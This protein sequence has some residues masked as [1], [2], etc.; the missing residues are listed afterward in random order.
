MKYF[1]FIVLAIL[2]AMPLGVMASSDTNK[3]YTTD[4]Y[5]EGENPLE[6]PYKSDT[7]KEV[8][9]DELYDEKVDSLNRTFIEVNKYKY[10]GL[11]G[12][13]RI[14][15]RQTSNKDFNIKNVK[16]YYEGEKLSYTYLC[17]NCFGYSIKEAKTEFNYDISNEMKNNSVVEL[18]LDKEY[19]PLDLKVEISYESNNSNNLS[20]IDIVYYNYTSDHKYVLKPSI[21]PN[22]YIVFNINNLSSFSMLEL[23]RE[24]I[25]NYKYSDDIILSNEKLNEDF[26]KLLEVST[27]YKY[28]DRVYLYYKIKSEEGDNTKVDSGVI[29]KDKNGTYNTSNNKVVDKKPKVVSLSKVVNP[30]L[31][32]NM[33]SNSN[34]TIPDL[35]EESINVSN[36][37]M[38]SE[39]KSNKFQHL[40]LAIIFII[41]FL[42]GY[43]L[44]SLKKE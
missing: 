38:L 40:F 20:G 37:K 31:D 1:K 11:L 34:K 22:E 4:Y 15:I 43:M 33:N 13:D 14:N 41:L 35:K 12:V 26:Y 29:L 7:F 19:N 6:Y 2:V 42:M 36:K 30:N 24:N 8:V 27:K 17:S 32:K 44:Y 23:K 9:S 21:E 5:L 39:S 25:K 28:V 10:Q 18:V 16:V 3:I